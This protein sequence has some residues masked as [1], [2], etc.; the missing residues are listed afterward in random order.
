M[1][2]KILNIATIVLFLTTAIILGLFLFGEDIPNTQY[3]T[4][5]YTGTLLNWV[6]ILCGI[7]VFTALLFP[8]IRLFTRPKQA[9]KS[10]V[11]LLGI[12]AVV[13][14]AYTMAD[15]TPM[16]ITGYTGPDNVPSRLILTDT[17]IYTMY[18]LFIAA[19]IAIVTTEIL[20]RVR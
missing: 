2:E 9:I 6:Y 4:P 20:R 18:F 3:K 7:A 14:I 15:G 8:T 16:K 19:I 10:F 11:G 1:I 5:V 17:I 12:A 13:L